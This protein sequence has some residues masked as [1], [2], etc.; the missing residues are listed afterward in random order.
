MEGRAGSRESA[1]FSKVRTQSRRESRDYTEAF[2]GRVESRTVVI[3]VS[4]DV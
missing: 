1:L 3:G 4:A 2:C